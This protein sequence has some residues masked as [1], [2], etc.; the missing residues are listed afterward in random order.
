[1]S[2]EIST[3]M[4]LIICYEEALPLNIGRKNGAELACDLFAITVGHVEI[5]FQWVFG[6]IK[7]MQ[8]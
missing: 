2:L 6:S 3:A 4:H 5:T 8:K 1:M 7:M